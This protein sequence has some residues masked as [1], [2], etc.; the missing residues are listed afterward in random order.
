MSP[1]WEASDRRQPT[2]FDDRPEGIARD[3]WDVAIETVAGTMLVECGAVRE[4]VSQE[5]A[6][7]IFDAVKDGAMRIRSPLGFRLARAM[8]DGARQD[9]QQVR[10]PI[11]V[12]HHMS[13]HVAGAQRHNR[14]ARRGG[15][16]SAR[17]AAAR[18]RDC[19]RAE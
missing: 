4:R 7:K 18:R 13:I 14:R 5:L 10:E 19:R 11:D 9:E 1:R 6:R 2:S 8:I 12:R 3:R 16:P 15:R 17:N